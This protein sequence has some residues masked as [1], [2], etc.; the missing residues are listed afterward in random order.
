MVSEFTLSVCLYSLSVCLS[1]L[2][3]NGICLRINNALS[4][5]QLMLMQIN[6]CIRTI[7]FLIQRVQQR[8]HLAY[9]MSQ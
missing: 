5:A 4:V 8:V 2:L 7:S 9:T 6:F 3:P 1:H